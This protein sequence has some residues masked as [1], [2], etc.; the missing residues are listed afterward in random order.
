MPYAFLDPEDAAA[1]RTR[2]VALSRKLPDSMIDS[3]S[4]IDPQAIAKVREQLWP[5]VRDEH[6]LHDLLLS[7]LALPVAY[8]EHEAAGAASKMQ[9][10]DVFLARLQQHGRAQTVQLGGCAAWVAAEKM[11]DAAWL[12]PESFA[13]KVV[14]G[15]DGDEANSRDQATMQLVRDGCSC[16]DQRRRR[17]LRRS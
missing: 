7:L 9:H 15:A 14:D 17:S 5:D 11:S 6:E 16:L 13:A 2:A 12:W 1:R 10:W 8:L 3:A 4:M